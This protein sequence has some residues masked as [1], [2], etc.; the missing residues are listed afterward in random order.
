M[1][2][3]TECILPIFTV[4]LGCNK[5]VSAISVKTTVAMFT[6]IPKALLCLIWSFPSSVSSFY[7]NIHHVFEVKQS[8]WMKAFQSYLY[9]QYITRI[10]NNDVVWCI[11]NW[12]L[13]YV[14]YCFSKGN[15]AKFNDNVFKLVRMPTNWKYKAF[16]K[17]L[18]L[19]KVIVLIKS[20]L[21]NTHYKIICNK[22]PKLACSF[23]SGYSALL[24]NEFSK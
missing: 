4:P 20:Y 17:I 24:E 14:D 6:W 8:L 22:I 9:E 16:N 1:R 21:A 19:M 5:W 10:N 7:Y 2:F 15:I 3:C 23:L 18:R 11:F 12:P 13:K